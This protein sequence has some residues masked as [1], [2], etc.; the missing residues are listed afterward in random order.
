MSAYHH[1]NHPIVDWPLLLPLLRRHVPLARIGEATGMC[2]RTINR[3]A[4]GEI[5]E[6]R[7]GPGLRL[8]DLASDILQ[9]EEWDRVCQSSRGM[10]PQ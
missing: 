7:F 1:P 4:R 9:P 6:P 5:R 2:E 3:L 8:L 10:N